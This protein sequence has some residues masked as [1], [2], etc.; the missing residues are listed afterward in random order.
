MRVALALTVLAAAAGSAA[1]SGQPAPPTPG[2]IRVY[3]ER[4]FCDF[5]HFRREIGWVTYV[6]DRRDAQVH[7]IGTRQSSGSGSEYTY[8]FIGL[9]EFAGRE[10]TLR[11]R[12]SNTDT[13]NERRDGQL[14]AFAIG[15]L[16]YAAEAEAVDGITIEYDAPRTA[17]TVQPADDRWNFWVFNVRASGNLWG[18]SAENGLSMSGRVT[19]NR[20]TEAWK[21]ELRADGRYSREETELTDS[22]VFVNESQNWTTEGLLVRSLSAHWSAGAATELGSSTFSNENFRAQ[23]AAALEY[24]VFPYVES[25]R[26][27]LAVLYTIGA[28]YYDWDAVTLFDQTEELRAEHRLDI[29][30]RVVQ[31]WGSVRTSLEGHQFFHDLSLHRAEFSWGLNVR[32]VRGLNIGLD[33]SVA[34]IK[35]Q[36]SL[37]REDIPD[38]ELL[39]RRRQRGTAFEYRFGFS[40]S[41][42]FG[43]IFNN[44]VNPRIDF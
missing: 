12:T 20:V 34:R 17:R 4:C 2:T 25:T 19:A 14:R 35:D 40:V 37:P 10:D 15:M 44:V 16:R 29:S 21:V 3:L 11:F 28:V 36:I 31:P 7:V 39:V 27:Q 18:E 26:R 13:E 9:Q 41:Y 23:V 33:G 22:T 5:D 32:V 1:A 43:S 8:Y 38:E 24:S 30:Y 42:T 6:N